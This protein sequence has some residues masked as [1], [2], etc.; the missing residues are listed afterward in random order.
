M[1][2]TLPYST[3]TI[4]ETSKEHARVIAYSCFEQQELSQI[5]VAIRSIYKE[6]YIKK[7]Q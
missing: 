4:R 5:S 6:F 7:T 1:H 3:K 2:S